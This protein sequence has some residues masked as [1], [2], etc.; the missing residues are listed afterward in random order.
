MCG[1]TLVTTSNLHPDDL[2][3]DG[4]QR[5]RFLPAIEQIKQHTNVLEMIGDTDYR[6]RLLQRE[7]I[8]VVG[9]FLE[10]QCDAGCQQA[11]QAHFERLANGKTGS[12]ETM[13][14]NGRELAVRARSGDVLWVDFET[15]CNSARSTNDYIELATTFHTVL[16]SDIPIMD[17]DQEDAARRLVN[18][19]DEFYDRHVKL[20]ISAQAK[21][22]ELYTGTK[23]EFEFVRAASRLIEMQTTEYLSAEH[24]SHQAPQ[25]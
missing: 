3:K 24:I 10:G 8:Y 20:V 2:Y 5:S 12:P 1:V 11:M 7:A 25:V 13:I 16:I 22:G 19:V 18:L 9:D 6:L 15:L 23:L 14:V 4:L 17:K 21:P